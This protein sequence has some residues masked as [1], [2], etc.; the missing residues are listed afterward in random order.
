MQEPSLSKL[1]DQDH[2]ATV[3]RFLWL[4]S[5]H[6]PVSVRFIKSGDGMILHAVR[7]NRR[8]GGY[9]PGRIVASKTAR[10]TRAHWERIASHLEKAKFWTLPTH[11]RQPFGGLVVDG[12]TLVVEGVNDGKYHFV[13]RHSLPGGN[14]V[15]LCRAMLFMSRI[16][17]RKLWFDYRG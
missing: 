6:D 14:F 13:V 1:A 3:Y 17:V 9:E 7:L 4:P 16:D 2:T 8:Q 15:D 10:L 5:F 11:K 12:D